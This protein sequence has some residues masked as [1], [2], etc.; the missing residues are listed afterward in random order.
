MAPNGSISSKTNV[1]FM[2]EE[3]ATGLLL[4]SDGAYN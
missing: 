1:D 2:E 3:E 4:L